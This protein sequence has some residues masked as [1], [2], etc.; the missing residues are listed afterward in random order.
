[1]HPAGD[2]T[3]VSVLRKRKYSH[4]QLGDVALLVF[5]MQ[6]KVGRPFTRARRNKA[7]EHPHRTADWTV[8]GVRGIYVRRARP[9]VLQ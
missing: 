8:W 3:G 5:G 4:E 1:M 2:C 6:S 9:R 7:V